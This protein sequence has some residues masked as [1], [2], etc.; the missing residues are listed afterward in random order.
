MYT[1]TKAKAT[2]IAELVHTVIARC[3]PHLTLIAILES[4]HKVL[5]R[6]VELLAE[7]PLLGA[8]STEFMAMLVLNN[9]ERGLL[10]L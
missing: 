8:E 2:P 5:S 7:E 1:T 6:P 3:V 4:E 10:A 9:Q